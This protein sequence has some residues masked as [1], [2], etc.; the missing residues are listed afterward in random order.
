MA[1]VAVSPR[2]VPQLE[3]FPP[4]P[5]NEPWFYARRG[6]SAGGSPYSQFARKRRHFA[7]VVPLKRTDL[8]DVDAV[9]ARLWKL[10]PCSKSERKLPRS[11]ANIGAD[12]R[13]DAV[14]NQHGELPLIPPRLIFYTLGEF[15]QAQES[16][17]AHLCREV[18]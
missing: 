8:S 11:H 16:R 15:T 9:L 6:K 10:A 3:C 17:S 13:L 2:A 1:V 4:Q 18:S 14:R 7:L 12:H 5:P